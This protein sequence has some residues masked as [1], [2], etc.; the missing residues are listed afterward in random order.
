MH[1]GKVNNHS[2][3]WLHLLL[4]LYSLSGI[5]SKLASGHPFMSIQFIVLYGAMLCILAI[6]A[7]GWQQIIKH[8]PLTS[9]YANRAITIVWG[10]IWGALFFSEPITMRKAIGSAIVLVG[11]IVFSFADVVMERFNHNKKELH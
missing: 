10:L 5:M 6:Y 4:L 11:V 9:A 2:I 8:M 7:I 3:V 1:L